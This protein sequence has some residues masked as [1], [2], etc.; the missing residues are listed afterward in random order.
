[1]VV[2]D[3]SSFYNDEEHQAEVARHRGRPVDNSWIGMRMDEPRIDI[4]ALARSYGAFAPDTVDDP[5]RLAAVLATSR[6]VALSGGVA[7][8]HVHTSPT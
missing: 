5:D 2:N 7:V 4:A 8:V 1:M 3:N 6:D